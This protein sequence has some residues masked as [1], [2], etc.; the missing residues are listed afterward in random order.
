MTYP[1]GDLGCS[2]DDDDGVEAVD[3]DHLHGDLLELLHVQLLSVREEHNALLLLLS[4]YFLSGV[5]AVS[6]GDEE[7][8]GVS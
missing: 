2:L 1:S 3:V 5:C 7:V 8:E 4:W 6:L